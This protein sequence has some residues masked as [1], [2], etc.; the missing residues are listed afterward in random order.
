MLE[1]DEKCLEK[2]NSRE[3][4]SEDLYEK[5]YSEMEKAK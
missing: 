3:P 2:Y 1:I 4:L 5:V